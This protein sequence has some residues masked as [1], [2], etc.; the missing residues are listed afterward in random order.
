MKLSLN[1]TILLCL[2]LASCGS[3]TEP[4]LKDGMQSANVETR[5]GGASQKT[6][7]LP[8]ASLIS[9]EF[10]FGTGMALNPAV[11]TIRSK[12]TSLSANL[13]SDTVAFVFNYPND[14][15]FAVV[16]ND[17]RITPIIAYSKKGKLDT[18]N[19]YVQTLFLDNIES[20]LS[21]LDENGES[22]VF[23]NFKPQKKPVRHLVI[24]PM[25]TAEV[26]CLS[27][28]DSKIIEKYPKQNGVHP[29][30]V[31]V[32]T[33][34]G[35]ELES[36]T[37][38]NYQYSFPWIYEALTVGP[39]Y[40]LYNQQEEGLDL[41]FVAPPVSFLR[42]YKGAVSAMSQLFLD[43]SEQC[44]VFK[45][46]EP[47]NGLI[48]LSLLAYM[49]KLNMNYDRMGGARDVESFITLLSNDNLAM[50]SCSL[51]SG[52]G[53]PSNWPERVYPYCFVVDGIDAYLN[54]DNS[55]ANAL[56][57]CRWGL[58]GLADGYYNAATLY[59]NEI[60]TPGPVL[61]YWALTPIS[62]KN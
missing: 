6:Y 60:L 25:I 22:A 40:G 24:D 36:L 38:N 59:E 42:T 20:Y 39:D 18:S 30:I 41:N 1:L 13:V 52:S 21:R 23:P 44:N 10:L 26:G 17:R 7:T 19:P 4:D 27:P 50:G 15:G 28:F 49:S 3:I 48:W 2:M 11:T 46:D 37:Y 35:Y 47:V 45:S 14:G 29:A 56:L 62:D 61:Q 54:S 58:N 31:A 8:Q 34:A 12:K 33:I 57:H 9:K 32:T 55:F 5:A 53:A 16:V 51:R 43:H